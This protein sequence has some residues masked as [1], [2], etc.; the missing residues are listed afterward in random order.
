MRMTDPD[1]LHYLKTGNMNLTENF[2]IPKVKGI[3]FKD[4]S[5][6]DLLGFNYCT[7][8]K[9]MEERENAF[10]HF[11]LPDH[12]IERVWNA[13]EYYETVF[14]QYKGIVQPDFS[15]YTDMPKAMQIWN[16]YRR[17]WLAQYYQA[18]DI[19]V[20]PAPNWSDEN[21]FEWCF[22]GEPEKSTV[23]ISSVGTQL[24]ER[25]KRLF[26]LGYQQMMSRL[27]P[28]IVLFHGRI[29]AE[30]TAKMEGSNGENSPIIVPIAAY[31]ER[32]RKIEMGVN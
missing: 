29:P 14:S 5:K 31:Q 7:N 30:I 20:I 13:P 4:L 15:I 17:N 28:K 24:N 11:F 9:T 21:S 25:S 8:P 3:K 2:G 1:F 12:Y 23:A 19:R 6:V 27:Q 26:L 10:V 22:D 16:H 32:L 18:K